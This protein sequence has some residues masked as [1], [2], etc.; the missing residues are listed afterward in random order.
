MSNAGNGR[1]ISSAADID[2]ARHGVIEAHAGTGKT[3]TIVNLVLR[4]L[5]QTASGGKGGDRYVHIREALLVTYTEKAAGELKKRIRDGLAARINE[6]RGDTGNRNLAGHL[7]ICLNNMHEAFIGTIHSVCLR[8]LQT[9]PFETGAH[10]DTSLLEDDADGADAALRASMRTDWE[11]ADSGLPPGLAAMERNGLRLDRGHIELIIK[12]ALEIIGGDDAELDLTPAG[13][14]T[15]EDAVNK[16]DNAAEA[17][18]GALRQKLLYAFINRAAMIL[19]NRYG[20]Y[21]RE[22]GLVSYYDMLRLTRDAVYSENGAMLK[23]LRQRLRYGIIDEFQDTSPI[24]WSIF[25]KIFLSGGEARIFIVGDPKQS[26]YSFQG[27]DINSYISAKSAIAAQGGTVYRLVNNYRSLPEMIEGY[28][29]VLRGDEDWFLFGNDDGGISYKAEDAACPPPRNAPP[30]PLTRRAVQAVKL[31]ADSEPDNRRLMAEAACDAVKKLLGTTIS[32]PDGPDWKELTLNYG[33]FAVIIETHAMTDPFIETFRKRGIPCVK[34]KM[35]GV[36]KSAMARDL[37]ALLSAINKRHSR[38][39]RAAALLTH[40]FNKEPGAIDPDTDTDYCPNPRCGGDNLCVAHA[41]DTWGKLADRQLWARLF[42]NI[43]EKTGIRR[44]LIRLTDGERMLADLRQVTDY[45]VERLYNQNSNLDRLTKH[46]ARMYDGEEWARG[47]KNLHTLA[48]EKSSVKIL[49]MHASKGLEFPVVF[50]M[51]RGSP[52]RLAGPDVLRWTGADKKR[53]FAPFI[54]VNDLRETDG[55]NKTDLEP[56]A[57][58]NESSIRERRRLLYV[59]MTRPQAMLFAPM[60]EGDNDLTPRLCKLLAD[61]APNIE[62]FNGAEWG[63]GTRPASGADTAGFGTIQLDDIPALSL[64]KFISVETSYSR[65]SAELKTV[66]HADAD[67]GRELPA[68]FTEDD[69]GDGVILNDEYHDEI[70]EIDTGEPAAARFSPDVNTVT[71][72]PLPG[73]RATGNALHKTIEKLMRYDDVNAIINDNDALDKLVEQCLKSGGI[74]DLPSTA[75]PA[76]AVKHAASLIKNALTL[77]YPAPNGKDVINLGALPKTDRVPEMEFLLS[78]DPATYN[79]PAASAAPQRIRGF[80]DLA[81]RLKNENCPAHPYR[82]YIADW[83]SD[84]LESYAP[85]R[86]R[87]YCVDQNYLLQ[88]QIYTRALDKY[89]SGILGNRYNREQHIGGSLYVF[90]RGSA[91]IFL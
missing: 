32:I 67:D 57:R 48:T 69:D 3:H 60:R 77:P 70:F 41:V 88:S 31:D 20:A 44:R 21:K 82:Y 50:L 89:L 90:L 15:L 28:N 53:R 13:G 42:G 16:I 35:A 78:C 76:A 11:D 51:N 59:A 23:R 24:Q 71:N 62:V 8:L 45:C 72:R 64:Q 33:D 86:L 9:W 63:N 4:M 40:F 74:L 7:E 56:L 6:L 36:F 49:T 39:H 65:I 58:Y 38:R 46:L 29:A 85:A 12:T 83:K 66:S 52:K 27:A 1:V 79:L 68:S 22:N 30:S 47:D 43:I 87:Q 80:I 91:G 61:N 14:L 25:K 54:G 73:G 17:E 2:L 26:I 84:T 34:Y 19:A 75:D 55:K 37:I 18:T 5:E 10:F 81:F